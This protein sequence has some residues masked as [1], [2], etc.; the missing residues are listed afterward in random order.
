MTLLNSVRRSG[1]TFVVVRAFKKATPS[2]FSIILRA[3]L[4]LAASLLV[5]VENSPR[6]IKIQSRSDT[7]QSMI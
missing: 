4:P 1:D 6:Q 3:E 7:I 2:A 5:S